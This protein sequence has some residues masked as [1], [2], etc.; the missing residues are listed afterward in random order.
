MGEKQ[1]LANQRLRSI[2]YQWP[3]PRGL[4]I[5]FR[6][7]LRELWQYRY[8]LK[9]LVTT[10]LKVR[11]QR[12]TLGFL[13]TLLRPLLMLSVLAV[14]FSLVLNRRITEFSLYLF[15]GLV[16]WMFF[17]ECVTTGC[18]SLIG[19]EG[20]IKRTNVKKIVF[21]L[22]NVLI[23][24]VNF[25]FSMAALFLLL[26]LAA[27]LFASNADTQVKP[28]FCLPMACLPL[29]VLILAVFSFG[30][31][32]VTLT[33]VVYFRDFE[34]IIGVFLQTLYFATAILYPPELLRRHQWILQWN[35]VY[36][37]IGLIKTP[38]YYQKWPDLRAWM[39]S[40][41]IAFGT[42]AVGYLVYKR[43][44]NRYIFRL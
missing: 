1:D 35:P 37:L 17:S 4:T 36:H 19:C 8:V 42:L 32:L 25:V 21:P 20:L 14:F 34:H 9:N 16:P 24:A 43:Y 39:I 23:A 33:L 12:S 22:S 15:S 30:V 40:T 2:A 41:A 27:A 31:V 10:Q 26:T 7:D 5:G 28:T 3:L 13:W 38:I 18:H 6:R 29:G 44:E 11:Y